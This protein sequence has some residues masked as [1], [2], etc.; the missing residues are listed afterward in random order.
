MIVIMNNYS[1]FTD[2]KTQSILLIFMST[3]RAKL[4]AHSHYGIAVIQFRTNDLFHHLSG[5]KILVRHVD[6]SKS[7]ASLSAAV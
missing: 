5:V 7:S 6:N 4:F 3:H 1:T 2:T